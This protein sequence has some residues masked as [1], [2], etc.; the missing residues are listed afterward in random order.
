MNAATITKET[1]L[2]VGQLMTQGNSYNKIAEKLKISRVEA[3]R[4]TDLYLDYL[5]T[6][7]NK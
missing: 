2:Q 3:I 5:K 1:V 6:I 7:K 4:A